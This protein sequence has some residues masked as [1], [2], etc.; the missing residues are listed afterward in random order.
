MNETGAKSAGLLLRRGDNANVPV[1]VPASASAARRD[2]D[3]NL[4]DR[5]LIPTAMRHDR[6]FPSGI[7]AQPFSLTN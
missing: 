4:V 3:R 7:F 1:R 5:P 2:I 6:W